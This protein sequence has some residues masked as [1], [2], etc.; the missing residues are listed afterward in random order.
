MGFGVTTTYWGVQMPDHWQI[1]MKVCFRPQLEGLR[2]LQKFAKGC[3][4]FIDSFFVVIIGSSPRIRQHL[5]RW[6]EEP[7][8]A[9]SVNC[10]IW[11]QPQ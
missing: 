7:L 2:N 11:L 9:V 5:R 10:E 4:R 6:Q 8:I 1:P 3:L